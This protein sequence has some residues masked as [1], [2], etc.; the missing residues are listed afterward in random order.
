MGVWH[1]HKY[2]VCTRCGHREHIGTE[3][4]DGGRCPSCSRSDV[5]KPVAENSQ[6]ANANLTGTRS[7][8]HRSNDEHDQ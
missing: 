8:G 6:P 3:I 7:A 5:S 2:M 1:A 4:L